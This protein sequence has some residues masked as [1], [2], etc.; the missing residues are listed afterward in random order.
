VELHTIA[1][2]GPP[3]SPDTKT[4]DMFNPSSYATPLDTCDHPGLETAE[5][6]SQSRGNRA[7]EK[8]RVVREA[9]AEMPVRRRYGLSVVVEIG[10]R[11]SFLGP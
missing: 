7:R 11:P 1:K 8:D 6:P 10:G 2:A 5:H 4:N 3:N 9:K